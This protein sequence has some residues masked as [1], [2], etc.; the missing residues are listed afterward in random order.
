MLL[1]EYI[2][3]AKRRSG[4]GVPGKR[5]F[6][7]RLSSRG[8][9]CARWASFTSH[10]N[11]STLPKDCWERPIAEPKIIHISGVIVENDGSKIH[12]RFRRPLGRMEDSEAQLS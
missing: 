2:P 7:R 8:G 1:H 11:Q 6:R 12:T 9:T 10:Q 5:H 4:Y 3:D